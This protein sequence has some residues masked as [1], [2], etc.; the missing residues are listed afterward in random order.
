MRLFALLLAVVALGCRPEKL[1][2][3]FD[4]KCGQPCYGGYNI[5]AGKGI[6][7][8]GIWQCADVD[9]TPICEGW[10][11][12]REIQCNG[13]DNNCD[14]RID[15]D[16]RECSSTCGKSTQF[17]V[18]GVWGACPVPPP[19]VEVCNGLDDDCNGLIDD[20][21]YVSP[22][23]YTGP[24]SSI[25][26]GECR[27]GFTQCHDGRQECIGEILPKSEI[28]DGL[29]NDCDGTVD[30]GTNSKPKD[31]VVCIDESGSMTDKILKVQTA[32]K[33]WA[34]KYSGRADLKFALEICPGNKPVEDNAVILKQN[35]TNA[36]TFNVAVSQLSA[37]GTAYEPTIDAVYITADPSNPLGI[38]W[39]PG[40]Q[41]AM[42][43]FTDEE[44]QNGFISP[45]V[46][47]AQA[48]AM[49][50]DA[51]IAVYGFI[52]LTYSAGFDPMILPT[53]GAKF[54]IYGSYTQIKADLEKIVNSCN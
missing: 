4:A 13:L 19:Q 48:G 1:V 44:A 27:P 50:A 9:A 24:T 47:A 36:I 10:G 35:L 11:I 45:V 49:A 14:G 17:C 5:N 34:N 26:K 23:C 2:K 52:D 22:Y 43:E 12:P 31:I 8:M 42:I 28:C 18:E 39:T 40:A 15:S 7:G 29:D 16:W 46:T 53:G 25:S 54:N 33:D 20:V 51:G 3:A 6:C 37:G 41:R 30:E 32:T 38:N 21:T